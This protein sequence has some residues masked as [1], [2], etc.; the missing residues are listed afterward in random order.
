[1]IAVCV[2]GIAGMIA[3]SIADRTGAAITAG[4]VTAVAVLCLIL[5]TAAA[6]PEAFGRPA[7]PDESSVA[8]VERRVTDLVAAGTDEAEVRALVRA[9]RRM[10]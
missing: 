7:P 6:G 9:V 1:M 2:A 10:R 4:M 8:D 3:S 5:V